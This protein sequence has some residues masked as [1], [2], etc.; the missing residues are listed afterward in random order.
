MPKTER[1][2]QNGYRNKGVEPKS[3]KLKA[4]LETI[5]RTEKDLKG[6][7]RGGSTW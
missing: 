7:R 5:R 1:K 3:R 2:K 4:V 6:T